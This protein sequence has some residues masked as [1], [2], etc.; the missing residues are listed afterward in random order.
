[1]GRWLFG[2][3][4]TVMRIRLLSKTDLNT[5]VQFISSLFNEIY[6]DHSITEILFNYNESVVDNYK[7]LSLALKEMKRQYDKH[8]I[9]GSTISLDILEEN[10]EYMKFYAKQMRR[11]KHKV[12][13]LSH[14]RQEACICHTCKCPPEPF[15]FEKT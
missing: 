7:R 2:L 6:H 8:I 1:M 11:V 3:S 4:T 9:K 10:H 13:L 15:D 14:N 5:L 12:A